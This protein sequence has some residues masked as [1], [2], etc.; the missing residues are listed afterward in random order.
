MELEYFEICFDEILRE[1]TDSDRR[2][3]FVFTI[4]SSFMYAEKQGELM[5]AN[6][7]IINKLIFGLKSINNFFQYNNK[8]INVQAICFTFA[9]GGV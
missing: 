2:G 1:L 4:I 3:S 7:K 6:K 9:L 5:Q 8:I